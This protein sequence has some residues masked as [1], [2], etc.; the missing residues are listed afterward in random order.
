MAVIADIYQKIDEAAPFDRALSFDNVGLLV[1]SAQQL[2]TRILYALDIVPEVIAEAKDWAAELIISH[3]PVIFSPLRKMEGHSV[4][5]LLARA[6]LSAICAHTN[7]DIAPCIGVNHALGS[8]LRLSDIKGAVPENGGYAVFSGRLPQ[9]MHPD[10]LARYI[11]DTL[12]ADCVRLKPG[13]ASIETLHFSCG[14]AGDYLEAAIQSGAQAFL[15]GE[16][17]HHEELLAGRSN[18]TVITAG[19]Y[20]TEKWFSLSLSHYLHQ[21]FPEIEMRL[22][23]QEQCYFHEI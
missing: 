3:H 19:H 14:A 11:K 23:T 7:L 8:Q 5:Y 16:L 22:S 2:V 9:P 20:D 15:T 12:A 21:A 17:K 10:A 1:G 4:P 18:I 6:G 13:A